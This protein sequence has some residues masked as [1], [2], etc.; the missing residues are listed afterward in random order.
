M[1]RD[2]F[3]TGGVGFDVTSLFSKERENQ[4]VWLAGALLNSKYLASLSNFIQLQKQLVIFVETEIIPA[5]VN[6]A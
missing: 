5:L 1:F 6:Q 2:L 3:L 4:F